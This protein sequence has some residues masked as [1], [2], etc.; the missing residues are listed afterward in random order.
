[1]SFLRCVSQPSLVKTKICTIEKQNKNRQTSRPAPP[2]A[3]A[4]KSC[5]VLKMECFITTIIVGF[6]GKN[7]MKYG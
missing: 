5:K 1:M 4:L 3:F 7:V 2:T 6:E